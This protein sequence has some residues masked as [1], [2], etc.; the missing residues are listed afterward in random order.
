MI[1]LDEDRRSHSYQHH[2][3]RIIVQTMKI[4]DI[5]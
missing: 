3:R 4:R 5:L 2:H 1:I